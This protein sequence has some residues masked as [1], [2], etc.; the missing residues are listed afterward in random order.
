MSGFKYIEPKTLAALTELMQE[1]G[2]SA[3]M[4]AGGTD[5]INHIRIGK[6]SPEVVLQISKVAE[7]TSAI[8]FRED[9][10]FIGA[11]ATLTD[12]QTNALLLREYTALCEAAGK[13]GSRQIRN[14]AT[15][16]GN[17]CNA[18]PAADTVPPLLL[19]DASVCIV[20]VNGERVL[21]VDAFITGPGRTALSG[22]EVVAG[23][24][25][26]RPENRFH[27]AYCKLS[28]RRGVDLST[29]GAAV[30]LCGDGARIALGAVAA[31]AFRAAEAEEILKSGI[32]KKNIEAAMAAVCKQ[33]SPITDVRASADYRRAMAGAYSKKAL[34]IAMRRRGGEGAEVNG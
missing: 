3:A 31:K 9:G 30:A 24:L 1:Y 16:A 2:A 4:M 33:A 8:E 6:R 28:R 17:I 22:G 15:M 13:V 23:V 7:L 10:I 12:I 21:P 32:D 14:H 18:S 29:V 27:S 25:I 5:L 19:F 11:L 20:G 26:P 34:E